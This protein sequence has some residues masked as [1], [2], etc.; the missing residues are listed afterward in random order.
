[1]L[2]GMVDRFAMS[3]WTNSLRKTRTRCCAPAR[4]SFSLSKASASPALSWS[5]V[6]LKREKGGV[7][8]SCT[9]GGFVIPACTGGGGGELNMK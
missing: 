9:E 2:S 8:Q 7:V 4:R 5:R 1:M 3:S 6:Y